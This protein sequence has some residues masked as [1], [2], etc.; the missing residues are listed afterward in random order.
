MATIREV[1][2][3]ANVSIGVVSRLL[4][5]DETLSITNETRERV[6]RAVK[7]LNYVN[8][9]NRS[10]KRGN[11]F[12]ILQWYSPKQ[13]L[14]DPYY[15][16]IRLGVENYCEEHHI[17]VVRV[18]KS[19]N[20]FLD[21]LTNVDALICIGKFHKQDIVQ[22]EKITPRM[23]LV[24]MD[25]HRVEYHTI[26]LDFENAMKDVMEYLFSRDYQQIGYLGG[27]EYL[28][29][30]HL[31]P[32]QRKKIF[33]QFC[34]EHRISYKQF[35]RE[36]S[37]SIE[38]GYNMMKSL[39]VENCL[40]RAVFAASDAIAIGA[41]RALS[42]HHIQ[43]PKDLAIIGF[44]D[45]SSAKYTSPPLSTV[46][47]PAYEMG[48]YAASFLHTQYNTIINTGIPLHMTLPCSLVIRQSS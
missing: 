5:H 33:I 14:D 45:I 47:A 13:E 2:K 36:D 32:D 28:S 43:I 34:E 1:A 31:Y 19:D 8:T 39:I 35:M 16:S 25:T 42:E 27:K 22:F 20:D 29:I 48:T 18:F 9:K 17:Q 10:V 46:H 26:S 4:N 11:V 15:L 23:V 21:M 3:L 44:D 6:L 30:D 24:D 12:G 40:P 37:F 41:M 38:S 7:E